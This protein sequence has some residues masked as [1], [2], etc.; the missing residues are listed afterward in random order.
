MASPPRLPRKPEARTEK[1]EDL[2]ERV[3]RG[4]VRVPRFQRPLKWK[5]SDVVELFDSIYRGYPIGA[6][7]FYKRSA[8]TERLSLGPLV[9]DAPEIPEA[10][11]VVDGQQRISA[12]TVS[13]TRAMPLPCSSG[14]GDPYIIFFDAEN[15]IFKSPPATATSGIPSA[16]VPVP[17]LLSTTQLTEWIYAWEHRDDEALRARVFEAGSRIREYVIIYYLIETEDAEAT[18]EIFLRV[19]HAGVPLKWREVHKALFGEDSASPSTLLELS[20][21]LAEAGMGKLDEDRLLTCLFALRGVDPTRSLAEHYRRDPEILR[22]AV[23]DAL[24][25]LRR[26]LSFLRKDA[27]IPHLRL[28]PKS[29]LLDVLA[30]VFLRFPEPNSRTRTLLARWFWRTLLGA[31]GFDDRTLRRRG[32]TA[33][34]DEEEKSVQA[35]LRLIHKDRPRPLDLPEAFDARADDSRIALLALFHLG[36]RHLVSGEPIDVSGVLE[37]QGKDVFLKVLQ[38]PGLLRSRSAANRIIHPKITAAHQLLR[39]RIIEHGA[40]DPVLQSHAID[41]NAAEFLAVGDLEGFLVQRSIILTAE[42]HRFAER[43]AAWDQND[44][45]SVDYLLAE[46]G[47]EG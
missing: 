34:G 21:R 15:Q 13:L 29:I 47:I 10:W 42:I 38:R 16:W 19:N 7:L 37:E 22:G 44:R 28:L 27:G 5:S 2:V 33:V 4:F 17:A 3:R 1:V 6:L 30:R 32:I 11:W 40:D 39:R 9:I 23:Q 36:P 20:E 8:E 43:M 41:A 31:G 46:A 24:P 14:P 26:V 35:L 45:P 25:V 18:G 12:L